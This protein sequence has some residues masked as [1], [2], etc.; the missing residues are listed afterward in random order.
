MNEKVTRTVDVYISLIGGVVAFLGFY[1]AYQW[2]W[3][4]ARR[5]SL[6]SGCFTLQSGLSPDFSATIL[7]NPLKYVIITSL[8]HAKEAVRFF[9]MEKKER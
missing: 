3:L 4:S 7:N 8:L 6:C 1:I 2:D 5:M 9:A